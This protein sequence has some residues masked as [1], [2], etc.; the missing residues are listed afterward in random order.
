MRFLPF[1]LALT[2][3][4][5]LGVTEPFP[6][7]TDAVDVT[8]DF[9]S[10][11]RPSWFVV[12]NEGQGW[13][14]ITRSPGRQR[15]VLPVTPRVTLA[16]GF[17]YLDRP[18]FSLAKVLFVT[19][20]EL[21][22][23]TCGALVGQKTL[24]ANVAGSESEA[25]F[26]AIAGGTGR[27]DP[28]VPSCVFG[29]QTQVRMTGV[30]DGAVDLLA[31]RFSR[32]SNRMEYILRHGIDAPHQSLLDPI[33]FSSSEAGFAVRLPLQV[34]GGINATV[35]SRLIS[36]GG[37]SLELGATTVAGGSGDYFALLPWMLQSTDLHRVFVT[38]PEGMS[39][40]K[41][42][43]P[44]QAI[45]IDPGPA[46]ITPTISIVQEDSVLRLRA[47]W[48][49]QTEYPRYAA[50][51]FSQ[52]AEDLSLRVVSVIVTRAYLGGDVGE[53]TIE[54]PS[55]PFLNSAAYLKPGVLTNW[56]VEAWG[57]VPP[58]LFFGDNGA[59]AGT[60]VKCA[61]AFSSQSMLSNSCASPLLLRP[62]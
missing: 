18:V 45:Q 32:A 1:L 41:Y 21:E 4:A 31:Y 62:Y 56:R 3:S 36:T 25:V 48:P 28:C 42:V 57:D 35:Q 22:A 26:A 46:L 13:H 58:G 47:T 34:S 37:T 7:P 59:S 53:W 44:G 24:Y 43:G 19:A 52:S 40:V 9:C 16:Y 11:E 2:V 8:V 49:V 12:K 6:R 29:T 50:A 55:M 39:V 15:F 5:C 54:I 30:A 51:T 20:E 14:V 17:T 27:T 60:V 61:S 10:G 23:A 33:D 38:A